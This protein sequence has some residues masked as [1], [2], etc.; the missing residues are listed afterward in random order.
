LT[1]IKYAA[2]FF[3]CNQQK[4]GLEQRS[5]ER[6][7]WSGVVAAQQWRGKIVHGLTKKLALTVVLGA[8][9]QIGWGSDYHKNLR[10][11]GWW[12]M[13][14]IFSRTSFYGFTGLIILVLS[15]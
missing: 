6:G 9:S 5:E 2:I 11:P 1:Y 3:K 7:K 12:W 8:N 14:L 15:L 13:S 10:H 4:I